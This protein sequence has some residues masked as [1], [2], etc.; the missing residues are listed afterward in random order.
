MTTMVRATPRPANNTKG[1]RGCFEEQ[2]LN[3]FA[4]KLFEKIGRKF[5]GGATDKVKT[6]VKKTA[7][8]LIPAI[9]GVGSMILGFVIFRRVAND[10]VDFKNSKPTVSNTS[11]SITTKNYFFN[12]MSEETIKSI[13]E[14]D[15]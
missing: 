6:E 15:K 12:K 10:D 8:D 14:E 4:M 9:L 3:I 7:L 1:A 5:A 13:L 11:T 2:L